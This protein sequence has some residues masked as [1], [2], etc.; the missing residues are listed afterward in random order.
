MELLFIYLILLKLKNWH[1]NN[2]SL[3]FNSLFQIIN[4]C[5]IIK[6]F[7]DPNFSLYSCNIKNI[8]DVINYINNSINLWCSKN[9]NIL[10]NQFN[11]FNFINS[12]HIDIQSLIKYNLKL[13][14]QEKNMSENK[15]SNENTIINNLKKHEKNTINIFCLC[16]NIASYKCIDVLCKK[17]CKNIECKKHL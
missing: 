6:K 15:L 9:K 4:N 16:N 12:F 3:N 10:L 7:I 5:E 11:Q 2:N 13:F 14:I 17:C 8:N 1:I